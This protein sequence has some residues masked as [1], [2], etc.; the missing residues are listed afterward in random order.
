MEKKHDGLY[1]TL[2]IVP[3]M[4]EDSEKLLGE[5]S[6]K[7]FPYFNYAA[8]TNNHV[9]VHMHQQQKNSSCS[10]RNIYPVKW[11]IVYCRD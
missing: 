9:S 8:G 2:P 7:I 3:H 5:A 11:K 4:M 10:I 1:A 6:P